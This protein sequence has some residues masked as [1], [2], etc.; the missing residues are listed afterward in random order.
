[1][2]WIVTRDTSPRS[3][4]FG[5]NTELEFV[6]GSASLGLGSAIYHTEMRLVDGILKSSTGMTVRGKSAQLFLFL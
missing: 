3:H 5:D 6:S 4:Y 2:V 1:M